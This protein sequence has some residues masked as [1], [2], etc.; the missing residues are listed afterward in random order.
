MKRKNRGKENKEKMKIEAARSLLKK[1]KT[2]LR[3]TPSLT[4][5]I[6]PGRQK[7]KRSKTKFL[8]LRYAKAERMRRTKT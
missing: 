5:I 4:I 6:F 1:N 3:L 7:G 2:K 8:S